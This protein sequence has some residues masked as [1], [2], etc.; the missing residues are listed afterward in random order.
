MFCFLFC[1]VM[2]NQ[3]FLF[4]RSFHCSQYDF[5]SINCD[6]R[7]MVR[8]SQK[9]QIEHHKS[10]HSGKPIHTLLSRPIK[11]KL[12]ANQT[13]GFS[14]HWYFISSSMLS[15]LV[16]ESFRQGCVMIKTFYLTFH[17][18]SITSP[19]NIVRHISISSDLR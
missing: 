4:S 13:R 18:H 16:E 3:H 12:S 6:V 15:P 11:K 8:P 9:I 17:H 5:M 10:H 2:Q 14:S 7:N 1:L 19:N